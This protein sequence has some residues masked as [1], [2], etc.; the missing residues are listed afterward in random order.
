[1]ALLALLTLFALLSGSLM[2]QSRAPL[3]TLSYLLTARPLDLLLYADRQTRIILWM[4]M[5]RIRRG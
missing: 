1:V 5:L 2:I 3:V 4:L